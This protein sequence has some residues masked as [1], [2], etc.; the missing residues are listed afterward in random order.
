MLI[1]RPLGLVRLLLESTGREAA[2]QSVGRF[3]KRALTGQPRGESGRDK[4][5]Q[6]S[7][8]WIV[9][10]GFDRQVF[11]PVRVFGKWQPAKELPNRPG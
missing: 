7:R 2:A 5:P 9:V 11:D 10:R 4:I 6:A 8:Y 1:H 3:L